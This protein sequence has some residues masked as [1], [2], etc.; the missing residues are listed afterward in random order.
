MKFETVQLMKPRPYWPFMPL[1]FAL[2]GWAL[3]HAWLFIISADLRAHVFPAFLGVVF[4]A[5][6]ALR[7]SASLQNT[8]EDKDGPLRGSRWNVISGALLL[9]ALGALLGGL[10]VNGSVFLLSI[11]AMPLNFVPWSRLPF[12]RRHP[13]V[14]AA[15]IGSGFGSA[16]LIQYPGIDV[17]FLPLATWS[18]WL[19]ACCGIVLSATQSPRAARAGKTQSGTQARHLPAA[20]DT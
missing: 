15:A 13:G 5:W 11:C 3:I 10:V 12:S 17:M 7:R 19:C 9:P 20:C 16:I 4:T 18:L 8:S 14:C 6:A 1:F 2:A